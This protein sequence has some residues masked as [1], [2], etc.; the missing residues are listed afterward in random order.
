ML[1]LINKNMAMK[2]FLENYPILAISVLFWS[3]G[4]VTGVLVGTFVIATEIN[5]A[6]ATIV[7]SVI[8]IPSVAFALYQA[9]MEIRER[10]EERLEME[11]N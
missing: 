10:F 3:M 5:A 6:M 1:D 4:I 11:R 7:T 2:E 9:R 8:G